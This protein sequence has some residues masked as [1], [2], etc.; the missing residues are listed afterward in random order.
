[1]WAAIA[2]RDIHAKKKKKITREDLGL[3][4]R[5]GPLQADILVGVSLLTTPPGKG[6][7]STSEVLDLQEAYAEW[8]SP[9]QHPVV[10]AQNSAKGRPSGGRIRTGSGEAF[11]G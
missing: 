1:M 5:W 10:P 9:L 8:G 11:L 7:V 4:F 6:S 3:I 2:S